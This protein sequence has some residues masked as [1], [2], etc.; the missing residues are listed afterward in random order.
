MAEFS[1]LTVGVH[2]LAGL[3]SNCID[4]FD[5]LSPGIFCLHREV[6]KMR[7]EIE[8][9]RFLIWGKY[10][11]FTVK[12]CISS[13]PT[14][15]G[16]EL[17]N[18]D[19]L[20][21]VHGCDK[22]LEGG[23]TRSCFQMVLMNL[24]KIFREAR[25]EKDKYGPYASDAALENLASSVYTN[26][27]GASIPSIFHELYDRVGGGL[28][29]VGAQKKGTP[30]KKI[31]WTIH[32]EGEFSRFM[33]KLKVGVDYVY[34]FPFLRDLR[35]EEEVIE[36]IGALGDIKRLRILQEACGSTHK[37]L[38]EAVTRHILDI[39]CK[40]MECQG[41]EGDLGIVPE[42]LSLTKPEK[43]L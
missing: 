16:A 22:Q 5:G 11:G 23:F 15:A 17:D 24:L 40:H 37:L 31:R 8:K 9:T 20:F 39:E 7:L 4:Y 13:N 41:G 29:L 33:D 14:P 43:F 25:E 26:T 42:H 21:M 32:Y 36:D 12:P 30:R 19:I 3:F 38:R 18:T 34:S 35:I 2:G 27:P 28:G 1:G 6:L 10:L